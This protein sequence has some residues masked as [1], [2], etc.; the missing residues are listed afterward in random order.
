[1]MKTFSG[2][3]FI[4]ISA[5][6]YSANVISVSIA[7]VNYGG[8]SAV[9]YSLIIFSIIAVVLGVILLLMREKEVKYNVKKAE[10]PRK[11]FLDNDLDN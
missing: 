8:Q 5:I 4:L 6:L 3:I 7:K 9:G 1:M 2:V 10:E 11:S